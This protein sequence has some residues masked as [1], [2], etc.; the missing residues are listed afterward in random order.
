M[1]EGVGQG[2]HESKDALVALEEIVR[3]GEVLTEVV[4][5]ILG[6]A[7]LGR[8][9][10][11]YFRLA[12]HAA[13]ARFKASQTSRFTSTHL[14]GGDGPRGGMNHIHVEIEPKS[15]G[16]NRTTG[17]G[18]IALTLHDQDKEIHKRS[19]SAVWL[20]DNCQCAQ[21][22]N[23]DTRQRNF[24]TFELPSDLAPVDYVSAED[25]LTVL[26]NDGHYSKH[27]MN[28]LER[29][30]LSKTAPKPEID[31]P[32]EFWDSTISSSPPEVAFNDVMSKTNRAGI[33]SLTK[34]IRI[35]GFSF[36]V[37][38]PPTPEATQTLLEHI[39]PIRNTHYGGFY[40][41]TPDL[42][43]AD[44]AY[45]NLALQAHT[46]T[47]YFSEPAGLQAF[48]LLSHTS[49]PGADPKSTGT[50]GQSLL[51][52]GFNVATQLRSQH[53]QA[54][55]SLRKVKLPW[56]ASGNKGI[57]ISPDQT[58]PVIEQNGGKLTRIRWN[59]DDRGIVNP[60]MATEWYPAAQ[61]W[62]ALLKQRS[63]EYQFQLEPGRVVIFDNWRV[64]HGRTAFEGIRRI[65]GGYIP[66]DDFMSRYRTTNFPHQAVIDRNLTMETRR[67]A[68]KSQKLPKETSDATSEDC[69]PIAPGSLSAELFSPPLGEIRGSTRP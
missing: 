14:A 41:F 45:T 22:V 55:N 11:Q 67:K 59:N 8:S 61:K 40:D 29:Y 13:V 35:Y 42:A 16:G 64:L 27:P 53:R 63:N 3:T 5:W 4:I 62:N 54:F 10:A 25:S 60:F 12:R 31:D 23:Q 34:N 1:Q 47:T 6:A 39:G 44:T 2:C 32:F 66:R 20:R 57:A 21:C 58:Y 43:L 52:D 26:W 48:H 37:D 38:T 68:A 9:N 51:V 65:C 19:F 56:H 24:D 36:V 28:Y 15:D 30:F 7:L 49:P 46:D 17:T 50:G 69:F 18:K 33:A